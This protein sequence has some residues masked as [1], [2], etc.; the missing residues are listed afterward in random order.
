MDLFDKD[1]CRQKEVNH[2]LPSKPELDGRGDG[3]ESFFSKQ[4]LY[5][6]SEESDSQ[7]SEGGYSQKCTTIRQSNQNNSSSNGNRDRNSEKTLN[8]D[9]LFANRAALI[10]DCEKEQE[11]HLKIDNVNHGRS[12][13]PS[14]AVTNGT[15][16]SK[17]SATN[18]IKVTNTSTQKK[19]G[20]TGFTLVSEKDID[21]DKYKI[22]ATDKSDGAKD[23]TESSILFIG[24]PNSPKD[25]TGIVKSSSAA[26]S[27]EI[28][29]EIDQLKF[30]NKD[31]WRQEEVNPNS[32]RKPQLDGRKD[33]SERIQHVELEE[34]SSTRLSSPNSNT[35]T[36][37]ANPRTPKITKLTTSPPSTRIKYILSP[38]TSPTT[39]IPPPPTTSLV[40][41][42]LPPSPT[43][44]KF[45][46]S[47]PPP[48][49][50]SRIQKLF[51]QI[52]KKIKKS[53]K[54]RPR[55]IKSKIRR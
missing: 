43:P 35:F 18:N 17:Q 19:V 20:I 54:S 26:I 44:S 49:T 13:P 29:Q 4:P 21:N 7:L 52:T 55:I 42:L 23:K 22:N 15:I 14:Y 33:G 5:C 46:I 16:F 25:R 24:N 9:P 48:P 30:F 10:A 11:R 3:N 40:P 6:Y 31:R 28:L 45:S 53:K 50:T 41:T 51:N 47:Q 12:R 32:P 34:E 1:R 37:K 8:S 39:S 2:Y 27:T 38:P 36:I